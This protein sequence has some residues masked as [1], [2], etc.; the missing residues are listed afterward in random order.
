MTSE[1]HVR[2]QYNVLYSVF[3]SE[4]VVLRTPYGVELASYCEQHNFERKFLAN[5]G[6]ATGH[7][8]L[9][10]IL[11]GVEKPIKTKVRLGGNFFGRNPSRFPTRAAPASSTPKAS[12]FALLQS[13]NDQ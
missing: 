5:R 11:T 12:Y 8:R 2:T 13:K 4:I 3:P 10:T 9:K 7:S 1:T 6:G